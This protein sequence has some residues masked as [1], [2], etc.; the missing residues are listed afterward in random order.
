MGGHN[1]MR[2]MKRKEQENE[3]RD[4]I[5]KYIGKE[6]VRDNGI[7]SGITSLMMKVENKEAGRQRVG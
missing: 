1:L 4:I 2:I 7:Y 5:K 3:G 6:Q